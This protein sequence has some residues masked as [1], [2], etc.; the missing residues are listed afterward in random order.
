[1]KVFFDS[2]SFAKRFLEESGSQEVENLC[3]QADA[4]GLSI[5]CYP[6]IL[7]ALN[8]RLREGSITA[9]DY[10]F[11]KNRLAEELADVEIIHITPEVTEQAG[12]LLETNVLRAMDA[13]QIA[14]ALKWKP[15]FFATADLRQAK[16]ADKAGL[17][18]KTQ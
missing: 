17:S 8:R 16:A 6:E 13:L 2:S 11:A 1:M 7:S 10:H 15:D 4:L 3:Q 14:C 18:T 5:L 9:E 12:Q